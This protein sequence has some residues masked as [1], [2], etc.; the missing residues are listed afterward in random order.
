M[1][2]F[3]GSPLHD[4]PLYLMLTLPFLTPIFWWVRSYLH[5]PSCECGHDHAHGE[6]HEP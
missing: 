6:Q 5:K 1:G 2:H 4:V 3:C